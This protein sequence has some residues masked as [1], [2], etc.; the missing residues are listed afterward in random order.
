MTDNEIK[1]NEIKVVEIKG[2]MFKRA[3][4]K[5]GVTDR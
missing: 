5:A 3:A 2:V 1:V 4:N